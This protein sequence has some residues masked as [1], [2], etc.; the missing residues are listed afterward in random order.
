MGL[1]HFVPACCPCFVDV[2]VL[3]WIS[4]VFKPWEFPS[5]WSRLLV[6]LFTVHFGITNCFGF[7]SAAVISLEE[8]KGGRGLIRVS[9]SSLSICPSLAE[10]KAGTQT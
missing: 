2:R 3:K 1:M 7:F 8:L 4:C 6:K 9:G 5:A 10:T